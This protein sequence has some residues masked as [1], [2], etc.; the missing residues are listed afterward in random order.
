MLEVT[1]ILTINK[2]EIF[3]TEEAIYRDQNFI[4]VYK[5]SNYIGVFK[6]TS[7]KKLCEHRE[8]I[9]NLLF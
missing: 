1:P 8:K 3:E 7:F 2:G 5:N 4:R 9:I 6:K